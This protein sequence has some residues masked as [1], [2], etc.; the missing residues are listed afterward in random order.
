MISRGSNLILSGYTGPQQTA[1]GRRT[2]AW[3]DMPYV[4]VDTLVEARHDLTTEELM[5]TFGEAHLKTLETAVMEETL[6]Q[7]DAVIHARGYRLAQGDWLR[8]FQETGVV[9]CLVA[10]IDAVLQGLHQALGT[11]YHDAAERAVALGRLQREWALRGRPGVLELDTTGLELPDI[12]TQ[13]V[14]VRNQA[15]EQEGIQ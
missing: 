6:L 4:D 15:P 8:R 12:V 2:A 7:R 3:L 5:A 14:R 9:I 1:I 10:S 11:R 13:V